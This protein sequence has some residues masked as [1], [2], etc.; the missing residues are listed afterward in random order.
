MDYLETKTS[1]NLPVYYAKIVSDTLRRIA[2]AKYS[3]NSLERE[4]GNE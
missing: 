4:V 1:V 2:A 3:F